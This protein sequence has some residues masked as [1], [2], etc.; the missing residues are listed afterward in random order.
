[1]ADK[2]TVLVVDDEVQMLDIISFALETQG[3]ATVCERDAE[4]GWASF[5]QHR[6]ALAVLDV[7]LP[8]SS[9]IDLCRRIRAAGNLPVILLTARGETKDRIAGLE[10]GADDYVT[11]PFHPREL[12][13]RAEA[14]VRRSGSRDDDLQLGDLRFVGE[15]VLVG[16]RVVRL[17]STELRILRALA[18]QQGHT[19]T[20]AD[21]TLQG[22][23][24]LEG[25]GTREMLKTA[26]YRLRMH[27]RDAGS[28]Y[29]VTAVRG[30]G[31]ALSPRDPR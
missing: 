31:Y 10:A 9:G 8:R 5:Q 22:W 15:E 1:M 21:L 12:A 19:V 6:F 16:D 26:V 29:T 3:F 25:P 4:R 30:I 11:K 18:A 17:P 27:L 23:R 28:H 24:V 2:G 13:L 20:S 14:V 7:M